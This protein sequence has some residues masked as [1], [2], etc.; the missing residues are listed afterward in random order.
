MLNHNLENRNSVKK[1]THFRLPP[2]FFLPPSN[3][4]RGVTCQRLVMVWI[5]HLALHVRNSKK[6]K[7]NPKTNTSSPTTPKRQLKQV[8]RGNTMR[9]QEL[10]KASSS[11]LCWVSL[12]GFVFVFVFPFS[13]SQRKFKR[14]IEILI[15]DHSVEPDSAKSSTLH[16]I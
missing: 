8:I 16:V 9:Q 13:E 3:F 11:A 12:G 2:L 5:A 4:R 14:P 1:N 15:P 7:K 6:C 10:A